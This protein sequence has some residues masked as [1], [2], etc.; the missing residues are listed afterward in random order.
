MHCTCLQA[1]VG[2]GLGV[3]AGPA[4]TARE[5]AGRAAP[6]SSPFAVPFAELRIVRRPAGREDDADGEESRVTCEASKR[7]PFSGDRRP[8]ERGPVSAMAD[9]PGFRLSGS[10]L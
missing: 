8:P 10:H 3:G 5:N 2:A 7:V 4:V 6:E 9:A 1:E